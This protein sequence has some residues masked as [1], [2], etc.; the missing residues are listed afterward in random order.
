MTEVNNEWNSA[1]DEKSLQEED[2]S[3][4]QEIEV[5]V[6]TINEALQAIRVVDNFYEATSENEQ[7]IC[8]LER[9]ER[10][11]QMQY[12][13]TRKRTQNNYFLQYLSVNVSTIPSLYVLFC[14]S[15]TSL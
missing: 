1:S 2:D 5:N 4:E 3:K 15:D 7:L 8:D 10:D 6:T 12:Y 13:A 14:C 11:L 9:I